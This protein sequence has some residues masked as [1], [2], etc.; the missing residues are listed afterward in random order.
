MTEPTRIV[1]AKGCTWNETIWNPSMISTALWLDAAD[2]RTVTAP[3]GVVEQW[4]DKSGNGRNASQATAGNRPA[5]QLA[6]QNGLNAVR[7]TAASSHSLSVGTTSTWNFLHNGTTSA[8]F[9]VAQARS[10][11]DNPNAI[12]CYISTG[13]ASSAN[14]G[15]Y[16]AYDDTA[17]VS[18]NNALST[19]IANAAV[20]GSGT[21]A[22][23]DNTNDKITP[24]TYH[25]ISSYVNASNATAIN[26]NAGRIDGSA[27][28]GSNASTLAP[29]A[30]NS[31]YALTLGRDLVATSLDFTGNICEILIFNTQPNTLDRQRIEGYLA[32][33]WGLTANLPADHPYKTVGPTP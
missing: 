31:T 28:F 3:G 14:I 1:L 5:Y 23:L 26:R 21:Y 8:V 4:N 33:K 24:G 10:T 2:A 18:R 27:E 12:H 7:F 9:I 20:G 19:R 25:V 15:Y 17:S 6:T 30:S 22:V 13:G 29:S 16:I 11:G 32:H